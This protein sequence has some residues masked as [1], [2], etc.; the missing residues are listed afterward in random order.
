MMQYHSTT[1]SCSERLF[2][3]DQLEKS[4]SFLT[5]QTTT[6]TRRRQKRQRR[7]RR[8]IVSTM[9]SLSMTLIMYLAIISCCTTFHNKKERTLFGVVG[10]KMM[11]HGGATTKKEEESSSTASSLKNR[12]HRRT[13]ETTHEISKLVPTITRNNKNNNA[14][15]ND[16]T[17][18]TWDQILVK[19]AKR[20][21][22][23]GL[24]GA[25][26]GVVQVISLMWLRT[27][28]NYQTRYGTSLK[29]AIT[30]LYNDGGIPRFYRGLPFALVQAP[31]SRFV[32]TAA[33]DGVNTLLAALE[34]TKDW[35]PGRTTVLAS[36]VVGLARILLMPID[37][38]KTVL[39]VNS[40]EGFRSLIRRVKAGKFNVLYEGAFCLYISSMYTHRN[41]IVR[42]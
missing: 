40:A 17:N 33:N 36:I 39:Q 5:I 26:A 18:A 13:D 27:I 35:G 38:C 23:G 12:Q 14:T 42:Q 41:N 24:P 16:T 25:A 21:L 20:G 29:R 9:P 34:S 2:E 1:C 15:T 8:T 11:A 32:S 7:R 19:A 28:I 3:K 31:L 22:G 4:S 30:M 37:T 10:I 6:T